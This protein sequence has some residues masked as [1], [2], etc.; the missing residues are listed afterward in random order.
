MNKMINNSWFKSIGAL[1]LLVIGGLFYVQNTDALLKREIGL[2]EKETANRQTCYQRL[3]DDTLLQ[4]GLAKAFD[5]LA[6][7]YDRDAKFASDCHGYTHKLGVAAYQIFHAEEKVELTSK[8]SYCGFGFY[9][10]FMEELLVEGG[11]MEE[12]RAFCSYA[13]SVL[14]DK[15]GDA[16]GACYHGIGHGTVDGTDPRAWGSPQAI[17]APGL[18]FCERVGESDAHKNR[19]ASGAFNSLAILYKDPKYLLHADINDPYRMCEKQHPDYFKRPCYQEMNTLALYL[20]QF[21]FPKSLAYILKIREETYAMSAVD[22][23]ATYAA[24]KR[25]RNE[26]EASYQSAIT[27]CRL[28]S[29]D[30]LIACIRGFGAG[31]VESGA[32]G[33]EYEESLAFCHSEDLSNEEK[34]SCLHRVL[35]YLSVIY[36]KEKMATICDRSVS[37]HYKALCKTTLN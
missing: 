18:A 9:H 5:A 20:T 21:D 35:H 7:I 31:L 19:C 22:S 30:T 10:G 24:Q 23:L 34:K 29:G 37:S 27:A 16:E 14:K 25:K 2:C 15:S 13:G 8:A 17:V 11:T 33:R 36:S 26:L 1:S 32:P 6:L 12:A 4:K 28:L 3:L